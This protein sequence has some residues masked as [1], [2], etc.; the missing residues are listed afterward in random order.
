[1]MRRAPGAAGLSILAVACLGFAS[2]CSA[3][4]APSPSASSKGGETLVLGVVGD[5]VTLDPAYVS[6]DQS[7]YVASQIFDTLVTI[8]PGT[9]NLAPDLATSWS[10]SSDGKTWTF[11]LRQGVKFQDGTPFNA[12][13]V[14]YNFNRWYNFTGIQ[15]SP[16]V[17]YFWQ[18]IFGGFAH[19]GPG[20]PAT[21]LYKSCAAPDAS[22]A[23]ISLTAP[24]APFLSSMTLPTFSMSS[25]AALQKYDANAISGTADSPQFGGTYGTSHPVGTG[26]FMLKTWIRNNELVL[27]R[28]P[29]Y[30]G[31]EPKLAEV[32]LKP[33]A[34]STARL[35]AL[36]SG[37]IQGY[38]LVAPGDVTSLQ[39]AGYQ[40]LRR[41]AFNLGYVGFIMSI[42][43][44]NN[45]LVRQAIAYALNR[46]AVLK[47][48]YPAGSTVADQFVPS[49]VTGYNPSVPQYPYNP[50]KAKQLLAQAGL[51]HPTIKF[52]YPTGISRPYMPDPEANFE[53]FSAN[54]TAVGFKVIPVAEPWSPDY[55]NSVSSGK[56]Q[57][58][59]L[60]GTGNFNDPDNFLGT[61]FSGTDPEWGKLPAQLTSEVNGYRDLTN[62]AQRTA[63]YLKLNAY[64]MT[65]L[66]GLPY[67]STE[68]IMAFDKDVKGYV[69][70]PVE[71]E[72][73]RLV[74]IG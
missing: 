70:S 39:S 64:I 33:I 37:E 35:Q 48:E 66:P 67:A 72:P 57:V 38:D 23:V 52:W 65:V 46:P 21:S 6:D 17:S 3:G 40:V 36:E 32:I 42:A 24:S 54:L 60:G 27:V 51:P 22:T 8:A 34:D 71:I 12:S 28:N 25:P 49:L 41:P 69:P 26:A 55:L 50:A 53:A 4:S 44:T 19:P 16:N 29:H 1:M 7:Q 63:D 56:A 2:A 5:P 31:P 14:C 58:F 30:W 59:L 11:H 47:A 9:V 62:P 10:S 43:P 20:S 13:A 45:V 61:W 18:D 68:P 73:L 74:S 15:Q